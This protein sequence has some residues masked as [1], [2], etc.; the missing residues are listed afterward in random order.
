M[1]PTQRYEI[2]RPILQREKHIQQVAAETGI[3]S[4]TLQRYLKRYRD[5]GGKLES[6]A[7]KSSASHYHP[8][9]F[10]EEDKDEVVWYKQKHPHKSARQIAHQLT[11]SGVL[12]ISY[13]S[14]SDILKAHR[15]STPFFSTRRPNSSNG[16]SLNGLNIC[17]R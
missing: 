2:I 8:N 9:G 7:N 11:E 12:K 17:S 6:L 3:S 15:L 16:A 10:T 13:H 4:R 5:S 1:D 14:V